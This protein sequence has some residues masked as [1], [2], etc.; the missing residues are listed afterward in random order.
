MSEQTNSSPLPPDR[1]RWTAVA[2]A[3]LI[4]PLSMGPL[5]LIDAD[6]SLLPPPSMVFGV[7]VLVTAT[8]VWLICFGAALF[9]RRW[10]RAASLA[11]SAGVFVAITVLVASQVVA[12][13]TQ[14]ARWSIEQEIARAKPEEAPKRIVRGLGG[15]SYWRLLIYDEE[16]A[17]GP[18]SYISYDWYSTGCPVTVETLGAH[19]YRQTV[20]CR[21][22]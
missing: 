22:E 7:L 6:D 10:R 15:G 9:R 12:I 13:N 19:F 1:F 3:L 17:V 5:V 16:D 21:K 18:P 20:D 14:L 11:A 4:W 8:I 2:A